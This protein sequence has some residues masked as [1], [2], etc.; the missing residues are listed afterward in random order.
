MNWVQTQIAILPSELIDILDA[1]MP[2]MVGVRA[3]ELVAH[4]GTTD[5]SQFMNY[6]QGIDQLED[7]CVIEVNAA[8]VKPLKIHNFGPKQMQEKPKYLLFNAKTTQRL[9]SLLT[10]FQN[11]LKVR[12]SAPRKKKSIPHLPSDLPSAHNHPFLQHQVQSTSTSEMSINRA[13]SQRS[14]GLS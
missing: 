3:R 8:A 14:T 12:G 9:S 1:P 5:E 6:I 11:T 2:Y 7:K 10:Q 13:A 4:M